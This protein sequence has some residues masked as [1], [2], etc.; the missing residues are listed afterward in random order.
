MADDS[1][2]SALGTTFRYQ[3][4]RGS[5]KKTR[6]LLLPLRSDGDDTDTLRCS[7]ET[8]SLD[9]QSSSYSAISYTWGDASSRSRL[10]IDGQHTDVP[11]N[12]IAALHSVQR[13]LSVRSTSL[14]KQPARVWI[15]AV[16]INQADHIERAHQVTLMHEIY[17]QASE[18]FICLGNDLPNELSA[19]AVNSV[20]AVF[21]GCMQ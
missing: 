19:A 4:F 8:V 13:C 1:F 21:E 3:P 5:S 17:S 18:V 20:H 16:S 15:D 7:I 14:D 9:K 2:G 10:S 12:T 6:L 11:A